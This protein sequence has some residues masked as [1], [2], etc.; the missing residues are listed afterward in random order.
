M[1]PTPERRQSNQ[2]TTLVVDHPL[3]DAA[4]GHVCPT[5]PAVGLPCRMSIF[6]LGLFLWGRPPGPCPALK[7]ALGW[8][9]VTDL[10]SGEAGAG[11]L[12]HAHRADRA[13]RR[14]GSRAT[15]RTPGSRRAGAPVPAV[16]T[17]AN[18]KGGRFRMKGTQ[19][20]RPVSCAWAVGGHAGPGRLVNMRP[21]TEPLPTKALKKG[22][23]KM[24]LGRAYLLVMRGTRPRLPF[25]VRVY[26]R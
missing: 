20:A 10:P 1:E 5:A 7:T 9:A 2:K 4:L 21:L 3:L 8:A 22:A 24:G 12:P 6:T 14:A 25:R 15:A 18:Q 19:R 13:P 11:A 16:A 26:A 17:A 23:L